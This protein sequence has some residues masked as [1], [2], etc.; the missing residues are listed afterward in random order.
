MKPYDRKPKQIVVTTL[1]LLAGNGLLA[2]LV[3]AF[4]IPHDIIM[5]GTTG[6]GIVLHKLFPSIEVASFVF[7]LNALLLLI[8]LIILGKKLF[9]TTVASTILYP[10]MLALCQRIPGIDSL[11]DNPLLAAVFAG[12]LMGIALGL[13]M[14]VGSSTGGMDIVNLILHKWLHLPIALFVYLTD[15][16]VVGGQAL[17]TLPEKTLLGILVLVIESIVLDK[18]MLV[19]TSQIQ[20][21]IISERFEELRSALLNRLQAGVTMI[22]IETGRLRQEGF[23]VLCVIPQNK[24]YAAT[25]LIQEI[26]PDAFITISQI[27]E[28]R[29]QGFT[30]ARK[31]ILNPEEPN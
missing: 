2:F 25:E 11:T 3:A 19:G 9:I 8:G 16:L 7:V 30:T 13:V 10:V 21:L 5:G 14:R 4:V 29:G 31:E 26:D 20:I 28:V 17:F 1:C 18:T 22:R 15:T 23:S 27:K 12:A 24:L 6:I